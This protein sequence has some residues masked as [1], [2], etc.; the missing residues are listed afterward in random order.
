MR[1]ARLLSA[2]TLLAT[3]VLPPRLVAQAGR[4]EI[5]GEVRD[6]AGAR[7][8]E[9]RVS[10]RD[11]A[12]GRQHES[13]TTS[14]GLYA[15]PGLT[16][17]TYA[18]TVE[19]EGFRRFVREGVYVATGERLRLD[20]DLALGDLRETTTVTADAPLL[21][22]ESSSLGELI[23]HRSVVQLPAERPQLP[24]AGRAGAGGGAPARLGVSPAQR[25]APT[26]E[27]IPLRRHFGPPAG[28]GHGAVFPHRGRH[29]GVQG[30]DERAARRV[31]PL[32]RRRDQPDHEGRLEPILRDRVRVRARRGAERPQPVRARHRPG[33]RQARVRAP[34]VR[35]RPGWSD[36][37]GPDLLFRRLSGQPTE[38]RPR[39][40]LDGAHGLA[41]AGHV[42]GD[43]R[44]A[45]AR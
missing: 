10:A 22:T 9:A 36:R 33:P 24:S 16:P 5:T 43:G 42:H 1:Q 45:R 12:T 44:R 41:A 2:A 29:P 40:D 20:V 14:S 37:E 34:P 6:P 21:Q 13:R 39:T 19:G 23:P 32:Q 31:R 27:R 28:A 30:R 35:V 8:A 38:H 15:L 7:I 18:L 17:G 3:C 25:R 26:R 11:V 4:G